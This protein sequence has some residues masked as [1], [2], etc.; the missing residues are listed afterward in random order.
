MEGRSLPGL[1]V[2]INNFNG[3]DNAVKARVID[4]LN[5]LIN[6]NPDKY[7]KIHL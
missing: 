3:G 4:A 6:Q 1:E 5:I 7:Y 2:Q